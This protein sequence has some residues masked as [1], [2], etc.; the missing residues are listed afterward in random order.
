MSTG[1]AAA[2]A[3]PGFA[4]PAYVMDVL[5]RSPGIGHHGKLTRYGV[6]MQR[7]DA[8]RY[9]STLPPYRIDPH[10]GLCMSGFVVVATSLDVEVCETLAT[11]LRAEGRGWAV[12]CP[13]V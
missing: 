6:M 11:R 10:A 12:R 1:P 4:I 13:I 8:V 5:K 2:P 9:L 3:A 7:R